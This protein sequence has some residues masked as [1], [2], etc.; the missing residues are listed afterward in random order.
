METMHCN[1]HDWL[2]IFTFC[3]HNFL[4]KFT[5]YFSEANW[6]NALCLLDPN[7]K[8]NYFYPPPLLRWPIDEIHTF[9]CNR[10]TN[11]VADWWNVLFFFSE[12]NDSP[13]PPPKL[14]EK[15]D[16]LRKFVVL[17]SDLLAKFTILFHKQSMEF[18]VVFGK[19]SMKIAG[20]FPWSFSRSLWLIKEIPNFF[21][22]PTVELI[23]Q[24]SAKNNS[25]S[26][27]RKNRMPNLM[28]L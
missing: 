16:K 8:I 5:I 14:M 12:M 19:W 2:L 1:F 21:S 25:N 17:S 15:M 27:S 9:F 22:W 18:V 10:L 3:Y 6:Q 13:P 24:I 4:M 26:N 7:N 23:F 20:F 28:Y 11:S